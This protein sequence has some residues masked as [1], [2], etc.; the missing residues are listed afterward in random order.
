MKWKADTMTHLEATKAAQTATDKGHY[1]VDKQ[2]RQG[3]T[4]D[5]T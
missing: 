3:V 5:D 1:S 2:C 4:D